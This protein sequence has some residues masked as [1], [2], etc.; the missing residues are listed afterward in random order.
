MTT[1][2]LLSLSVFALVAC[3]S[4]TE[5]PAPEAEA[6]VETAAPAPAP[7]PEAVAPADVLATVLASAE[8]SD[9]NKARDAFRNPAET[10]AFFGIEPSDT[11]VE[12]WPGRGWYTEVL[13][14]YLASG[15]GK[16]YAASYDPEGANERVLSALASFDERFV[17]Q[18][19]LY[20]DV[21]LTVLSQANQ[22][23]APAGSA[24][25]VVTFRNVHNFQMGGWSDQAFAAFFE[26]L[27]PGG[28]LGVVDHRLPEEADAEREQS[29]GYIKVSTIRQLAEEA[30]FV[31]DGE[32]EI[33][34]NPNDD[35]DHPFG[36]WTLPPNSRTTNRNG[37]TPEG[38]DAEEFLA[39]GESDRFTLRFKKPEAPEESLLE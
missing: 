8:R 25:F 32:S 37:E 31:F 17:Q 38:F 20:G 16:L 27:K 29:S 1:R 10:I 39:I 4:E 21:E 23:I 33:N 22:A 9:D 36:V 35:T 7:T 15:G 18:P 30:G 2:L 24:D 12:V 3:G 28:V 11:V 13:A 6:P 26:A 14:P 5:A 19:A 34:A